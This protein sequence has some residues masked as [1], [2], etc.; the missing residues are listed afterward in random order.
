MVPSVACWKGWSVGRNYIHTYSVDPSSN[1]P[2]THTL[3][4]LVTFEHVNPKGHSS[5]AAAGA[6]TM[7]THTHAQTCALRTFAVTGL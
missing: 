2:Q 5:M 3:P 4:S 7:C 1:R 6:Q